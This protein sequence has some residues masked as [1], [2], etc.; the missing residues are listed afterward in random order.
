MSKLAHTILDHING[1][2]PVFAR[3]SPSGCVYP[4]DK[5][6]DHGV[7]SVEPPCVARLASEQGVGT[8]NFQAL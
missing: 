2:S 5:A 7:W 8:L 3:R 1:N 6:G 4:N